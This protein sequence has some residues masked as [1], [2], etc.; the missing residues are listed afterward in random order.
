MSWGFPPLIPSNLLE[1]PIMDIPSL[2]FM[3]PLRRVSPFSAI[4]FDRDSSDQKA[5]AVHELAHRWDCAHNWNL[6]KQMLDWI[7]WGETPS[8]KAVNPLEDLAY[9]VGIL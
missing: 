6:S 5:I 7:N 2:R 9:T 1:V 4:F 8:V 3:L